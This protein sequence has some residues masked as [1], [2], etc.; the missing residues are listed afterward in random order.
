MNVGKLQPFWSFQNHW[1]GCISKGQGKKMN[2]PSAITKRPYTIQKGCIWYISGFI[3][4]MPPS[5]LFKDTCKS[6]P[7]FSLLMWKIFSSMIQYL[8]FV[9]EIVNNLDLFQYLGNYSCL[10][11]KFHLSRSIGF[12]MVQSYIPTILIVVIS[13][14]S[15]WM[16]TDSV[17]GRTTLG[18]TTLLTVSSK[19]AGNDIRR[20]VVTFCLP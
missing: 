18:V 16:D 9:S 4:K 11:A 8:G 6:T 5:C 2:V 15:F 12:H 3:G 1:E 14:V 17:P 10:V 13:W 19:S 20:L 7:T